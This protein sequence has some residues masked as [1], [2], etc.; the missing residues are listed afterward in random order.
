MNSVDLES[1]TTLVAMA[2]QTAAP[3]PSSGSTNSTQ[4]MTRKELQKFKRKIR[5]AYGGGIMT[6]AM[7]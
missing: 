4:K 1:S 5:T 2:N 6:L 3:A 7:D